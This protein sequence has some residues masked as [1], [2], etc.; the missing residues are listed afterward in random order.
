MTTTTMVTRSTAGLRDTLF[1][2][3]DGLNAGKRSAADVVAA[4]RVAG[5]IV[6]TVQLEI[7]FHR[8]V[9]KAGGQPPATTVLQLGNA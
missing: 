6:E 1:D 3:L 8:H 2:A 7:D 9:Q 4:C 5:A